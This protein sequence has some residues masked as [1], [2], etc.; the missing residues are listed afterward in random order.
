MY[1]EQDR[2][3]YEYHYS[4]RPNYSEPIPTLEPVQPKGHSIWK[5]VTAGVLCGT[6]LL[7]GAFGAGW[8]LR[9][10][11]SGG[12]GGEGGNGCGLCHRYAPPISGI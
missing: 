2:N 1:N 5:R 3:N 7:C 10:T 9:N 12:D 6:L 4:Y 11:G 8:F